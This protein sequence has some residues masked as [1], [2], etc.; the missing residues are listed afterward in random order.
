MEAIDISKANSLANSSQPEGQFAAPQFSSIFS[1]FRPKHLFAFT[2]T[3]F[4]ADAEFTVCK[5]GT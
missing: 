4:T 2:R 5:K 3:K 1:T